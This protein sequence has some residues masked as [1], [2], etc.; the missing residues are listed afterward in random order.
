[1]TNSLRFGIRQA[2]CRFRFHFPDPRGRPT[3]PPSL[4]AR[5]F[6]N[7]RDGPRR[8]DI[9][10]HPNTNQ[11]SPSY[12]DSNILPLDTLALDCA[13]LESYVPPSHLPVP[14]NPSTRLQRLHSEKTNK[15]RSATFVIAGSPGSVSEC[16]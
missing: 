4:P 9:F 3:G 1:M 8:W 15:P 6:I 7:L 14:W 11:N 5:L 16:E 13:R 2:C 12:R 10:V